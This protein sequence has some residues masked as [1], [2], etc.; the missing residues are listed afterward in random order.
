MQIALVKK[1]FATRT[2][3][4]H[5]IFMFASKSG[6]YANPSIP[7]SAISAQKRWKESTKRNNI[8]YRA[9]QAAHVRDWPDRS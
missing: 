4:H 2:T 5:A 3:V 8:T 1:F 6:T 9:L 7:R